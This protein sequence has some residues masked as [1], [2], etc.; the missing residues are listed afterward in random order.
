MEITSPDFMMLLGLALNI[1]RLRDSSGETTLNL[2]APPTDYSIGNLRFAGSSLALGVGQDD[3][4]PR[5][6]RI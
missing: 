6:R 4:V 1:L 2:T 5:Y 3:P